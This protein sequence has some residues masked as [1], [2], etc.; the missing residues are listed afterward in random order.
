MFWR[1]IGDEECLTCSM[2]FLK[3]ADL[4]SYVLV[5]SMSLHINEFWLRNDT[6]GV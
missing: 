2:C 6:Y 1:K 5:S 3:E 4:S